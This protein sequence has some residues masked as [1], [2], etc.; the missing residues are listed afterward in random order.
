MVECSARA[1]SRVCAL[2]PVVTYVQSI[3]KDASSSVS[4]CY[5]WGKLQFFLTFSQSSKKKIQQK[6]NKLPVSSRG[7]EHLTGRN[8]ETQLHD[9]G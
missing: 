6:I 1:R 2:I 5:P 3:M 7:N 8:I 4:L 9:L